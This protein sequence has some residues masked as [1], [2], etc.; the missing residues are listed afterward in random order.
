MRLIK[1]ALT[2]NGPAK[3]YSENEFEKLLGVRYLPHLTC[4]DWT[5]EQWLRKRCMRADKKDKIHAC[6]RWLGK[7]HGKALEDAFVPDIT[8]RWIHEKI[9]YGVFTNKSLAKW[10]WI[11]EYAGILRQRPLLFPRLNDYCFMY[12][13]EWLPIRMFTIDS[14]KEGNFTRFINHSD[15][16]NLESISVLH[17][18][19]FHI[20]FR[21][22]RE[23]PAGTE[24]TYDYGELYWRTRKKLS[25]QA[26]ETLGL[27]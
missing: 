13:R 24:L 22:I 15:F 1:I 8:I 20:I 3:L 4:A 5:V 17:K 23:I 12:P 27:A 21:P 25:E 26:K 6:S 2:Q 10:E 19:L 9:G 16:P 18:G 11:G 14:E 7:L